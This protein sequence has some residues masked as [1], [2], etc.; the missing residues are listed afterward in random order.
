M[1]SNGLTTKAN[2]IKQTADSKVKGT[3]FGNFMSS[4]RDR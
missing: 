1:E 4:K 2:Q 3:F